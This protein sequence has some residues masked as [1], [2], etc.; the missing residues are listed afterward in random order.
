MSEI[1]F[2]IS[3][4]RQNMSRLSAWTFSLEEAY[5]GGTLTRKKCPNGRS[6]RFLVEKEVQ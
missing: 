1:S 3:V 4:R 6:A 5:L 2:C